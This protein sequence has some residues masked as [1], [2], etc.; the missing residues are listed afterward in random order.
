MF[1]QDE[2]FQLPLA[3]PASLPGVLAKGAPPPA[4][5]SSRKRGSLLAKEDSMDL[6]APAGSEILAQV[7]ASGILPTEEEVARLSPEEKAALGH[8]WMEGMHANAERRWQHERAAF[9]ARGWPFQWLLTTDHPDAGA[10]EAAVDI[11]DRYYP[12]LLERGLSHEEDMGLLMHAPST[13]HEGIRAK[14]AP[15]GREILLTIVAV[16]GP[17]NIVPGEGIEFEPGAK[18]HRFHLCYPGLELPDLARVAGDVAA[19]PLLPQKEHQ[20]RG[21]GW[22]GP[23]STRPRVREAWTAFKGPPLE[24]LTLESEQELPHAPPGGSEPGFGAASILDQSPY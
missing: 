4:K 13:A 15:Y 7:R 9:S 20:W 21:E 16:T 5:T 17:Y 19:Y 24:S 3:D 18:S 10:L 11:V 6:F 12:A 8:V 2:L 14:R 22:T 23:N 1:H